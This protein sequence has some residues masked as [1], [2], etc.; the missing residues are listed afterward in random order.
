MPALATSEITKLIGTPFAYGGRGPD[1]FDCY[2]LVMHLHA[3]QGVKLPDYRSPTDQAVIAATMAT[4]L[5]L[6]EQCPRAPGAVIAIRLHRGL[7][8]CGVVL[9]DDRFIHTWERS[10][11]VCVE[12]LADWGHRVQGF[13]RYVGP[14]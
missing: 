2:G 8:H 3:R 12:R 4:Q 5:H 1:T 10:G 7:S 6:W 13:Y 14:R 9:E 11:G